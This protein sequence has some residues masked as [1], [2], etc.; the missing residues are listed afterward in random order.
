MGLL[1]FRAFCSAVCFSLGDVWWRGGFKLEVA[2][3]SLNSCLAD[4]GV[5]CPGPVR[6]RP[7]GIWP[8]LTLSTVTSLALVLAW[9]WVAGDSCWTLGCCS[10][11]MW[12]RIALRLVAFALWSSMPAG[13]ESRRWL[14]NVVGVL[15]GLDN[16]RLD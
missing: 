10:L 1:N 16:P 2:V 12:S 5:L 9:I 7:C 15:F 4:P 8:G 13:A 14:L 11:A 3:L 6:P